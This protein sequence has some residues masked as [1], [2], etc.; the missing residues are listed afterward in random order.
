M[1]TVF[2]KEQEPRHSFG[3]AGLSG[4]R[5]LNEIVFVFVGRDCRKLDVVM[6]DIDVGS[7]VVM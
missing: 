3:E 5:S 6:L 4:E 2:A 7:V 1:P